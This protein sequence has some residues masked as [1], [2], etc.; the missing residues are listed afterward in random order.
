MVSETLSR[1][2]GQHEDGLPESTDRFLMAEVGSDV[3]TMGAEQPDDDTEKEEKRKKKIGIRHSG[4]YFEKIP[5]T[6]RMQRMKSLE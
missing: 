1:I 4:G 3:N 2:P 5:G 6:L